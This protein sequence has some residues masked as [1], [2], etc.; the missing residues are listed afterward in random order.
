MGGI[1]SDN[2]TAF[3]AAGAK[4]VGVGSQLFDIA[5]VEAGDWD[6]VERK[7][8]ATVEAVRR[9]RAASMRRT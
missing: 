3:I 6:A 1:N 8:A 9:G 7:A 5:A 4:A 2:A